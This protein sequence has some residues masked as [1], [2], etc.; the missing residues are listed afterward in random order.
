MGEAVSYL[1]TGIANGFI[2]SM[3]A[4]GFILIFKCSKIFNFA[5][6]E[7]TVF[8]A[9]L[10][11]SAVVQFKLPFFVGVFITVGVVIILALM[12]ERILLRPLIGQHILSIIILTLGL[13]GFIR[14]CIIL[15]WGSEMLSIPPF[16]PKGGVHLGKFATLSYPH[17][18]FFLVGSSIILLLGIYYHYSRSGLAMRA[19]ADDTVIAKILGIKVTRVWAI[20]W[21]VASVVGALSGILLTSVTGIHYTTVEVGFKS[22]AVALVGG[23]E[24]LA[25]VI[26][27]GP[28]LGIVETLVAAYIDPLVGGGFSEVAPFFVLLIVLIFK[29]QGIFGWKIIERV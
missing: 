27:V 26:L 7:M 2:Y 24:S 22:M 9:Y 18:F 8:G 14:G 28:L 4:I 29:P 1:L 13:G 23:L 19:T 12:I 20:S 17:I 5:Q 10:V 15:I 3:I 25:G 21:V 6:A 16:F 11:Y